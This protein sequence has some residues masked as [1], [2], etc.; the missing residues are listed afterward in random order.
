MILSAPFQAPAL[1]QV[2]AALI[3]LGNG[4]FA[5]G[6]LT[7]A[8]VFGGD[9]MAGLTLGAWGAVQAAAAGVAMFSGVQSVTGHG[10]G[11]CGTVGC[12]T[13]NTRFRLW[14]GVSHR[15]RVVIHRA[16]RDG[17]AGKETWRGG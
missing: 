12:R 2:G 1:F 13:A 10:L 3:G 4:L 14:G 6:M 15:D 7:A 8:M 11:G 16:R 5:V 17:S 9:K